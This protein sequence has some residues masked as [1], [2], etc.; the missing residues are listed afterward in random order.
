[1]DLTT[2]RLK[3]NGAYSNVTKTLE[4]GQAQPEAGFG[5]QDYTVTA[6]NL[7]RSLFPESDFRMIQDHYIGQNGVGHVFFKQTAHGL[8]IDNADFNV[9]VSHVPTR[10]PRIRVLTF[11]DRSGW[12]CTFPWERILHRTNPKGQP[13]EET[14][15]G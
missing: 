2:F 7:V 1:M 4:S 15:P 14:I 11:I 6:S 13:F 12:I 5:D 3:I 9:N 8:D 10:L